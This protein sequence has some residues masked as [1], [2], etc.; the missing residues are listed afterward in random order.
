MFLLAKTT[1]IHFLFSEIPFHLLYFLRLPQCLRDILQK[2][3]VSTTSVTGRVVRVPPMAEAMLANKNTSF[4]KNYREKGIPPPQ[5]PEEVVEPLVQK[6]ISAPD[7]IILDLSEVFEY[8]Y[9]EPPHSFNSFV[10][11]SCGEMGGEE[12]RRIKN[13]KVVCIDC[14]KK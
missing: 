14:Q 13:G 6:V 11:K 5:V 7:E 9:Q 8:D 1:T 12:Y 4:F 2:I 10:C 3:A